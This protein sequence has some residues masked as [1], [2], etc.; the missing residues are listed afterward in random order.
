MVYG[1]PSMA[2]NLLTCAIPGTSLPLEVD[3]AYWCFSATG[4]ELVVA[5]EFYE[6]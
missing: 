2:L 1:R 4:P 6:V 3:L 5:T